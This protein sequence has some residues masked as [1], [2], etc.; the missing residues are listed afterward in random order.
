MK[1]KKAN[2][3]INEKS[4]YLLQH[5]YNP[6][7]WYTWNEEAFSK[8]K[9]EDK[10][11]FLSIGYSTC[12]WCHVMERESFEDTEV[13]NILNRNFIAIKVDREERP[14]IDAIYM[15]VCQM[16][17]GSGGWPLTIFLTPDQKPFLAGTYFPKE[18]LYGRPGLIDILN[19]IVNLWINERDKVN[20]S[21]EYII[22]ILKSSSLAD[23]KNIDNSILDKV[24]KNLQMRYD[25]KYGGFEISPK[26]PMPVYIFFLVRYYY[27]SKD[28]EALSMVDNTLECIYRGGI[29]DHVGFGFARYSTD[30]KWLVPHFEKMIYDNALLSIAYIEAYQLTKS[31]LYSKIVNDTLAY[32]MRDMTSKEGGFYSAI[33]ADSE[34]MEGKF[35]V[36]S[37]NEI[38]DILGK[39]DGQLFCNQYD[40]TEKGNFEGKNIPNLIKS[41]ILFMDQDMREKLYLYRDKRIHPHKDDK[42]LTSWNGLVIAALSMAGRIFKNDS[43]IKASVKAIDFIYDKLFNK[44]GRLL[45]RYRDGESS[46]LGY[47]NDYVFLI[48]GLIE[49]YETTFDSIYLQKAL[50]LNEMLIKY[51]WDEED[52]GLFLYGE[53]AEKLIVRP[54]EIYDGVIPSANSVATM[55]WLRLAHLTGENKF[56]RYA[57]E[58]FKSF[59]NNIA[60]N[61]VSCAHMLSSYL[62]SISDVK[63]IVIVGDKD[64]EKTKKILD[65]INDKYSPL[66]TIILKSK[67]DDIEKISS[68][69]KD[70]DNEGSIYICSNNACSKP[71]TNLDELRSLLE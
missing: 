27:I 44:E 17:T 14:D 58:Q 42:I 57:E 7:N 70:Y 29:Y 43:Y 24:Y 71:I 33:D 19:R 50:N 63:E 69:L 67:K 18:A 52:G 26:F 59:S 3:L 25:S 46:I 22:N 32:I 54:K 56:Q 16:L 60:T 2:N 13:A 12:H 61:P 48:W 65:L 68:F 41:N 53:D 4:P 30:Q 45:A 66:M 38:I 51:F 62:F 23:K 35:Y 21:S 15:D 1:Y 39:E 37:Y 8:A 40:I 36:W 64:D 5:A 9:K 10:P 34:G 28:K 11:I 49:L 31:E 6:V 20:E 47:V 55:N